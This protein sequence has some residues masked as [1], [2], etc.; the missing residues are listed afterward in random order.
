M[1]ILGALQRSLIGELALDHQNVALAA[2]Q[3]A[4]LLGLVGSG[5]LLIRNDG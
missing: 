1:D 5:F 3:L 2:K 4:D